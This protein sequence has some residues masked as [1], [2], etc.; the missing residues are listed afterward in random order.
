MKHVTCQWYDMFLNTLH[1]CGPH[2]L[3]TIFLMV[4]RRAARFVFND[5]S[6]YSSVSRMLNQLGW[7]MFKQ[8]R[9]EA[10][11]TDV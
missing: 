4:Q 10:K 1:V 5:F 11:V 3:N 6:R 8:Q 9:N 7:S 2:L